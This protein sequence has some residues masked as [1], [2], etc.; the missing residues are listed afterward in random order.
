MEIIK[1]KNN[2]IILF[3]ITL[4]VLYYTL[5]DNFNEIVDHLVNINIWWFLLAI[6]FMVSYWL[7]RSFAYYKIIKKIDNN[8]RYKRVFNLTLLTQ[9]FNGITPFAAGGQPL[10]VFTLKKDGIPVSKGTSIVMQDFI[11]YQIALISVGTLAIIYNNYFHIFKEVAF[12]KEIVK[13]GYL[14]NLGV[15]IILFSVSFARKSNHFMVNIIIRILSKLKLLKY[16]EQALEKWEKYVNNFHDGAKLLFEDI[17]QVRELILINVFALIF[18]YSIPFL[19]MFSL[20]DYT[21]I[22]WI[23]AFTSSAYIMI[24]GSFVPIPGSTG[25]LEYAF[26]AFFSNFAK[27]SILGSLMLL[28]RFVTYYLGVSIGYVIFYFWKRRI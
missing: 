2:L 4:G 12:L 15:L 24:V 21:S 5:K 26:I 13:I 6:I 14:M 23:Q 20:K 25:G 22:T 11:A 18:L 19:L 1:N 7:L 9:F 17:K 10:V 16:K 8:Y 28:W 27:G 3:I